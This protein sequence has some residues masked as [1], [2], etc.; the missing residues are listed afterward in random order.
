MGLD[1]RG[2]WALDVYSQCSRKPWKIL[3]EAEVAQNLLEVKRPN[4]AL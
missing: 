2:S 3:K 4:E 1:M